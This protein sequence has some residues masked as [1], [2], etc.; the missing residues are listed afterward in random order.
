[1]AEFTVSFDEP[2][3]GLLLASWL[4]IAMREGAGGACSA[5]ADFEEFTR[6]M[7]KVLCYTIMCEIISGEW[8]TRRTFRG[9]G[10]FGF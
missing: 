7:R 10:R 5:S 8:G 1:M 9:G 6:D 2:G 4:D 3:T